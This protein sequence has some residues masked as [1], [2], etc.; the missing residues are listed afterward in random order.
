MEDIRW[1]QR[2]DNYRKALTK[3]SNNIDYIKEKYNHMDLNNDKIYSDIALTIED[4][5]KQ[6]LIQSFEFTHELA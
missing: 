4:I 1:R 5:Y 2:F 3:L 6:G